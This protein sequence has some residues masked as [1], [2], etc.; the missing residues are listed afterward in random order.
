MRT[1]KYAVVAL[2]AVVVSSA[3][4]VACAQTRSTDP[5]ETVVIEENDWTP[6]RFEPLQALDSAEQHY[7]R[8]EESAAA[9][10]LDKAVAWL[11]MASRH[12]EPSTQNSL[13]DAA[14]ELT[15]LAG[16]LRTADLGSGIDMRPA[17]A[18][19]ARALAEWHYYR[20][21]QALGREDA[22][23]A[24]R[25]LHMAANYLEFAADSAH[26]EFGADTQNVVTRIYRDGRLESQTRAVDRNTIATDL[27][28]IQK[29]IRQL[30]DSLAR[31]NG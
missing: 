14:T 30:S 29:A 27:E 23:T 19:A 10:E 16:D 12:A 2:S 24:A 26:V 15:K 22:Q 21:Q 4:T 20:S 25:D 5:D 6:L 7:R 28:G 9:N 17:L 31:A 3:V 13:V 18:R 8:Q 11:R 1:L